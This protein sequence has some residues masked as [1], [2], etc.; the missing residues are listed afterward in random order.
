MVQ[1]NEVWLVDYARTGFS[2]S[3]PGAPQRDVL[4][5]YRTD[6]LLGTLIIKMF[7]QDQYLGGKPVEKKDVEEFGVGTAFGVHESWTYA[8]RFPFFQAGFP[9]HVSSFFV[10]KQCASAGAALAF[11][12]QEIMTGQINIGMAT[13]VEHMTR[14][15]MSNDWTAPPW[16]IANPESKWY[17]PELDLKNSFN[18]LQTAQRLYEEETPHFKKEDDRGDPHQG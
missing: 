16:D 7:E 18:M 11:V 6:E 13:G 8:G 1:L 4:S 9:V 2:R 3:R 12:A 5:E 17:R 14:I 10:D 15:P